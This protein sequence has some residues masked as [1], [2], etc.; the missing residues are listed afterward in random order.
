MTVI[1]KESDLGYFINVLYFN[2]IMR[3]NDVIVVSNTVTDLQLLMSICIKTLKEL[4]MPIDDKNDILF[5]LV[6]G[7]TSIVL[8][9]L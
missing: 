6:Q 7:M 4:D 9:F 1:L 2:S 5:V 8:K 3:A